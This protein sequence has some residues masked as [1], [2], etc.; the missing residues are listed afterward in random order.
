MS[1]PISVTLLEHSNG[2]ADCPGFKTAA[3]ACDLRELGDKERLDLAMVVAEKPCPAAGVF[4]LNDLCAAPVQLC[5]EILTR[6][7]HKVAGFVTNSGNANAATGEQGLADAKE[8]SAVAQLSSGIGA[9]FLICSTGRIGRKLPMERV[10]TGIEAAAKELAEDTVSSLNA[11]DAILT[12]DTRRKVATAQFEFEGKTLTVSGIAKGAGMIEPNMATM[13]AFLTTDAVANSDQLKNVLTVAV[14]KTFNRISI[15]G[16]MS[17][18]DTVLL[19][20]NGKSGIDPWTNP[21]L[22][23]AFK[24][25]VYKVCDVLAEKIVGDG[26]KVTKLI[27]LIVKGCSKATDAEE[28]A[29]AVGNSLLVKTSWY[30]SDPNW[31]RLADAAGYAR[32]GL[33]EALLDIHY[34]EVP[35]LIRGVP[36]DH[37]LQQ[38]KDVVSRN[39][40]RITINLNQGPCEYRLLTSDLSEAYVD[41]NKSE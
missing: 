31:G 41:F 16:D 35:A 28:V 38:W 15:D 2:I 20:A 14:N 34:N 40:F 18:N 10:K 13:L 3:V 36:Q 7:G 21:D 19:F 17:T 39:R 1:S 8:M 22:L 29:R 33:K 12:S 26:E 11:A 37:N 27:E 4:T 32:V 6:S 5:K 9:P 30:G 25:A 23:F 24:E